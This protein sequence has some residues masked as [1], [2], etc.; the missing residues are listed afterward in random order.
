MEIDKSIG[1]WLNVKYE[2]YTKHHI[3]YMDDLAYYVYCQPRK[4]RKK[5]NIASQ[6]AFL[7]HPK[8]YGR[9]YDEALLLI[10]KEKIDKIMKNGSK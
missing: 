8:V 3:T 2:P 4:N 10:R 7:L 6:A 5:E 1:E 9:F